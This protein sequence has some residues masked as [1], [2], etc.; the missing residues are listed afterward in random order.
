MSYTIRLLSPKESVPP[1]AEVAASLKGEG[2]DAAVVGAPDV[3]GWERIEVRLP[4]AEPLRVSRF[5]REGERTPLT[6]RLTGSWT[7][8]PSARRR[9]SWSR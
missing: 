4:A 1:A 8:W 3:E 5:L 2:F 9:R 6:R 7:N